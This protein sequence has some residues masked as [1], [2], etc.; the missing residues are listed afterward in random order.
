M[1]PK[2]QRVPIRIINPG[3]SPIKLYKG[4]S[5]GQLQE[6][7]DESRD[8]TF[9]NSKCGSPS[10]DSKIEFD[11]EHLFAEEREKMENLLNGHQDVFAKF[12]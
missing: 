10:A 3:T 2:A 9:I 4:M 7:D 12:E 11:L 5:L 6:V 1:Q 8:Q